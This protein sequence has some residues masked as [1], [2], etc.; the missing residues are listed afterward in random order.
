MMVMGIGEHE[1][2]GDDYAATVD[3]DADSERDCDGGV[4]GDGDG[5]TDGDSAVTLAM[6]PWCQP[7]W[8]LLR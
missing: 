4:D 5:D 2:D 6:T 8:L 3:I 7:G 1:D